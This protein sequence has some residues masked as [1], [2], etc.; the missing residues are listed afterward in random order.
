VDNTIDHTDFTI[1]AF[2]SS[3][4]DHPQSEREFHALANYLGMNG[5]LVPF[6]VAR[7]ADVPPQRN[8]AQINRSKEAL[9]EAFEEVG[10]AE[11]V[12]GL[13]TRDAKARSGE[14]RRRKPEAKEGK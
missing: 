10:L 6:N 1:L 7:G 13:K 14:V 4:K 8:G 2:I 11:H 12:V 5:I 3:Q 9:E